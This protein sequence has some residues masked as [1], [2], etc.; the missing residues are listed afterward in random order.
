MESMCDSNPLTNQ[1]G[2]TLLELLITVLIATILMG[3]AVP[4]FIETIERRKVIS[5]AE[6][7]SGHITQI[8]TEAISR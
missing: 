8:R 7:I 2:F 4:S 1:R 3:F 5:L 6:Q